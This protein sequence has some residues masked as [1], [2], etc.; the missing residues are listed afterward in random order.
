MLDDSRNCTHFFFECIA[1]LLVATTGRTLAWTS[2]KARKT[3][4]SHFDVGN[5]DHEVTWL[6]LD[7]KY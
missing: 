3:V 7:V 5:T 2:D 4:V 1:Y 6:L